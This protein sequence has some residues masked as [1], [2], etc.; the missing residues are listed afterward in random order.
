[1]EEEA[2][3]ICIEGGEKGGREGQRVEG[4]EERVKKGGRKGEKRR[5][6]RRKG[7]REEGGGG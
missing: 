7:M 1:M 5:G 6:G 3:E 4:S 2:Q